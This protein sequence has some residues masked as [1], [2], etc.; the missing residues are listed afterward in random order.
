MAADTSR[1]SLDLTSVSQ[2]LA[3][4]DTARAFA[5]RVLDRVAGPGTEGIWIHR[6]EPEAVAAEAAALDARRAAGEALPLFGVP[7]AVKDNIDVEG[8]PTTAACPGFAY[9]AERSAPVV[10]R[11]QAAGALLIG[12][13]NLDQFATGLVGTRSP[14]GVPGNP[15]DPR[16]IVGGSSSGSAAAV[17]RGLVSFALG[18]DTAGS[19]RVPAAFTN[20]VGLKPSRGLISTT[21]VV[22]ACRSLDCVSV[23]GLTVEDAAA[24]ADLAAGFD[25]QDIYSRR[26]AD[27]FSFGPSGRL[28]PFR[29]GVPARAGRA[30]FGDAEAERLFEAALARLA[31][32]GGAPVEVSLEP[33][34][35][36]A[37]L[38]YDG[39]WI[40]ER[41]SGLAAFLERSPESFLPITREILSEGRRYGGVEVFSGLHRLA[42]LQ[43]EVGQLWDE[44]DL[45]A[46]PTTPT[47][48]TID[49][50]AAEPRSLNARLGVYTN[51]VNLL[52]LAALSVPAGFRT[53][54]LPAGLSV[55]GP[56]GSDARLAEVGSR[57]HQS[58][59]GRLGATAADLPAPAAP[60][61]R[62]RHDVLR[63]VV[64][65]AHL[66][67]QPLNHQLTDLDARLVRATETAACY[68][69]Y[70][71]ATTPRKPGLV[72]VEA[73]GVSI[74]VEVWEL[75]AAALGAFFKGVTPPLAIGTVEL[76]DGE[77]VPGF[78]CEAYA[79]TGARDISTFGGWR[80]FLAAG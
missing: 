27:R 74:A 17:S 8:L 49:Q 9:R 23:F 4:G 75:P 18:T 35:Q 3:A 60:T 16:Y 34:L 1:S 55:I 39:P 36:A 64:V 76:A 66:Q 28:R 22:P 26:E 15:F 41:L 45:L 13:T 52:D 65:G 71:L 70:A 51:F 11:L 62:P 53:D 31:A 12:K 14:Y 46:V 79:V 32:L 48:Y 77:R 43:Q 30:F 78:V 50:I 67:G 24:V 57:F 56:W 20:L 63:L 37:R 69:L 33:F 29:F 80:A 38:L 59:G 72:R 25:A 40:A 68:R 61:S 47:I 54:G 6:R 58:L 7:F 10:Q 21:G 2:A 73:G 42:A 5:R 19:G 44:I